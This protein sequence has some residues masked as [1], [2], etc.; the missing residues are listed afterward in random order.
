MNK[1]N[2][3][4]KFS[5]LMSVYY[6]ENPEFLKESLDSILVNQTVKPTEVVFVED[7]KLTE[8]LDKVIAKYQKKFPDIFK[9][10][11]L[12]KN[13]GL[14]KALQYGLTKCK[15]DLIMRM[16]SD[17]VSL[18][19]RFEHQLKF[20]NE[21]EDVTVVGGYIEEFNASVKEKDK[22]LKAM[23]TEYEGILKYGRF[24][25]PMNHV[26]V[27]FRKKDILDVGSYQPLLYLEDH[28]L[29]SRLIV[30][31]KKLQNL[32]ETLVYVRIGNGFTARRGSKEYINNWRFLQN[33]LYENK[34][35]NYFEKKR[36]MLGIYT[37]VYVPPFVRDFLYKHFLRSKKSRG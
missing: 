12:E 1:G 5:V 2:D 23:P 13:Q 28:Y 9:V 8:K 37:M 19:K 34:V 3:N 11:P 14:G 7:G 24:R 29:W 21:H 16:D 20:M 18:P 27:C 22:R 35:I 32:P 25:N 36:N 4:Q 6:K 10:Y 30:A 31:G 33:Y 17:D 26:T 15:Y